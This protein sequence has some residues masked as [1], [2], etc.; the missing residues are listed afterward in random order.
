MTDPETKDK[1]GKRAGPLMVKHLID[2][3]T[4]YLPAD[5]VLIPKHDPNEPLDLDKIKLSGTY[6]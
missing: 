3:H 6:D 2:G 1:C 5:A 4:V